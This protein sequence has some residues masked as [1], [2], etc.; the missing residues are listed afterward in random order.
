MTCCV[1][2]SGSEMV[3]YVPVLMG[4]GKAHGRGCWG[5]SHRR[6]P[7][8]AAS[9]ER[10]DAPRA[11]SGVCTPDVPVLKCRLN[12]LYFDRLGAQDHHSEALVP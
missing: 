4:P 5:R 9:G 6:Q 1:V 11:F 12:F 7:G 8:V 3:P 10:W 2:L